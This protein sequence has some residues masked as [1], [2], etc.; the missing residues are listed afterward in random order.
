MMTGKFSHFS[1]H[2]S[3]LVPNVAAWL[4]DLVILAS[5]WEQLYLHEEEDNRGA[6]SRTRV[7]HVVILDRGCVV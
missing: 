7:S 6:R 2:A 3:V 4:L 5:S 1:H